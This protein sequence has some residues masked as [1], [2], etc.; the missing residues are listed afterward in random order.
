[1]RARNML[2]QFITG[3]KKATFGNADAALKTKIHLLLACMHQGTSACAIAEGSFA[4]NNGDTSAWRVS[5]FWARLR[6]RV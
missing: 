2:A 6:R 3:D 4:F 5:A 1:M